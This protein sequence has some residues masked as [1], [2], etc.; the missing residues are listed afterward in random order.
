MKKK[1][2][3]LL[4]FALSNIL[5]KAS[6]NDLLLRETISN[7][8]NAYNQKNQDVLNE[9]IDSKFGI[10]YI[11]NQNN[12]IYWIHRKIICLTSNCMNSYNLNTPYSQIL[13]EQKLDSLSF[14][15][16]SIYKKDLHILT[17]TIRNYKQENDLNIKKLN[18]QHIWEVESKSVRVEIKLSDID[19][20]G[21]EKF[22][23]YLSLINKRWHLTIID[24]S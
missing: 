12:Q 8:L 17:K 20:F 5:L 9:Y 15:N 23:F 6:N 3:I 19:N 1:I 13:L 22:V 10:Y 18:F 11:L 2:Y 24:F 4:L 7:V 14:K 16:F 21:Q